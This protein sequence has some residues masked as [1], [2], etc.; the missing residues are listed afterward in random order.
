MKFV[1]GECL[2][3]EQSSRGAGTAGQRSHG[4]LGSPRSIAP[5]HSRPL[6]DDADEGWGGGNR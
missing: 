5:P 4:L 2:R 3:L 1:N 6:E